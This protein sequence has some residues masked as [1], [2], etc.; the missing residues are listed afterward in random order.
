VPFPMDQTFKHMSLCRVFLFKLSHHCYLDLSVSH[1]YPIWKYAKW[2]RTM[3]NSIIGGLYIALLLPTKCDLIAVIR[4]A[5]LAHLLN[6]TWKLRYMFLV[7][8]RFDLQWD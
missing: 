1:Y 5:L 6:D 4:R 8:L 3:F 2:T 7:Y